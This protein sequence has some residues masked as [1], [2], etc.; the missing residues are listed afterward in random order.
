MKRFESVAE[1]FGSAVHFWDVLDPV[2]NNPHP[3][4]CGSGSWREA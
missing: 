3:G 2:K 1:C 4:L